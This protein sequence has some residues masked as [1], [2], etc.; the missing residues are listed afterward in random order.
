MDDIFDSQFDFAFEGGFR[1]TPRFALGLYADIGWGDAASG[2]PGCGAGF[3][4]TATASRF[5]VLVR[6]TFAPAAS[7]TP[8]ISLGTG[9]EYGEVE[10]D[11]DGSDFTYSGWQ[12]AR[13]QTGV[14]FRSNGVTGI[15]FYA[16]VALGRYLEYQDALVDDE[17][18]GREEFHGT[19][20]FGIRFTLF[21]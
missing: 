11:F 9:F 2:V 19:V 20:E 3:N 5:G 12:I 1:L 16:G 4:C 21:P 8:W 10:R 7:T 6:H 18:G 15:G 17:L 14:D 13:L